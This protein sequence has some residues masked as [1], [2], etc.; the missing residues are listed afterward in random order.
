MEK[1]FRKYKRTPVNSNINCL[2]SL[3]TTLDDVLS[4]YLRTE[5]EYKQNHFIVDLRIAIGV[6]STLAA[7]YLTYLSVYVD[8]K[9]YK[10]KA[11]A[12]LGIY[13]ALNGLLELVMKCTQKGKVFYGKNERGTIS[14]YTSVKTP[15]TNY[16]VLVYKDKSVIPT[17][18]NRN[19]CELFDE[20]GVLQHEVFLNDIDAFFKEEDKKDK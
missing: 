4:L 7:A 20:E 5:Q 17:K 9:D 15:D 1:L 16:V 10:N 12:L 14:V 6:I 2:K 8:F 3:K 13:F 19:I 18:Y 11:I